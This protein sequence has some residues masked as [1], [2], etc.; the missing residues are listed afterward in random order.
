MSET[1]RVK[2]AQRPGA[3]QFIKNSYLIKNTAL[4][5]RHELNKWLYI[6]NTG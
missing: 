2:E 6:K 1:N 3:V 4:T 5:V